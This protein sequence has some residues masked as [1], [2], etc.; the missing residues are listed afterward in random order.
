[1]YA[2]RSILEGKKKK[3]TRRKKRILINRTST[4]VFCFVFL[5]E[6][7]Q[8]QKKTHVFVVVYY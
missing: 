2:T 7:D 1:L 4:L 6:V 5:L 8:K 3:P